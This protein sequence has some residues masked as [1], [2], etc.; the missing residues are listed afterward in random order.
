MKHLMPGGVAKARKGCLPRLCGGLIEAGA[1]P[2]SGN[3]PAAV[4]SPAYAGASLKQVLLIGQLEAAA[5]C[6]PRLC[7]GL[8]EARTL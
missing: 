6:L 7:G 3:G 5:G 1:G 8:I 4:V 2:A